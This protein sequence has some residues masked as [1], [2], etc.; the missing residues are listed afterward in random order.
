[1]SHCGT[2]YVGRGIVAADSMAWSDEPVYNESEVLP[3]GKY[4]TKYRR[5]RQRRKRYPLHKRRAAWVVAFVSA[6]A[7]GVWYVLSPTDWSW[8]IGTALALPLLLLVIGRGGQFAGASNE[9][10]GI[11]GGPW[12]PP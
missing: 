12:G 11:D 1:M 8:W 6:I 7:G 5:W 2:N 3:P 4:W 10:G 9:P